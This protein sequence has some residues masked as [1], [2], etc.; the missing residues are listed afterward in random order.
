MKKVIFLALVALFTSITAIDATAQVVPLKATFT[1]GV[2]SGADSATI[3]NTA[4]AYIYTGKVVGVKEIVSI[5]F[6]CIETSGTLGGTVTLE[7]S[8]D[9]LVWV[10]VTGK[11]YTALDGGSASYFDLP[12]TGNGWLYYRIKWVG[13]GTMAGR[14]K[15]T[16]LTR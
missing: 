8:K 14:V 16:L 12:K 7:G 5:D 15:A 13:T 3:T 2:I 1:A 11:T 10:F 9:G 6:N 4:T